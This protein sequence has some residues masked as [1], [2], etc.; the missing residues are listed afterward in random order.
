MPTTT[1]VLPKIQVT[2][3]RLI[4]G[5]DIVYSWD[6]KKRLLTVERGVVVRNS[7]I[8]KRENGDEITKVLIRCKGREIKIVPCAPPHCP[9]AK[10]AWDYNFFRMRRVPALQDAEESIAEA[11]TQSR[12]P[13]IARGKEFLFVGFKLPH[14]GGDHEP[15]RWAATIDANPHEMRQELFRAFRL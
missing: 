9:V 1:L 15:F 4:H 12:E 14:R 2:E 8:Q 5:E 6:P 7:V 3:T 10:A 13:T 11:R